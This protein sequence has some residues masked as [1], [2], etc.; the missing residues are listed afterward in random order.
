MRLGGCPAPLNGWRDGGGGFLCPFVAPVNGHFVGSTG[1]AG[2][3]VQRAFK[4][5]IRSLLIG[6]DL[7]G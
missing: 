5:P 3:E 7:N 2:H 6:G 1:G 4:V